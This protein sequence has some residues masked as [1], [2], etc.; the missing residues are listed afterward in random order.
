MTK[1]I[2][3]NDP[4]NVQVQEEAW[5]VIVTGDAVTV[6]VLDSVIREITAEDEMY[7]IEIDTSVAG[8]TYVGQAV[9]G[10]ATS[11]TVW[12]IKKITETVSGSSV[13]WAGGSAAFAWS[14]DDH[15]SLTYGP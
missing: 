5:N 2:V 7:D 10:T 14:W 1:V 3:D 6:S 13:D 8:V 11:D 4:V 12:R 9:P 15:L